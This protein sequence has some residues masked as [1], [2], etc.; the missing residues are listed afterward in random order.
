MAVQRNLRKSVPVLFQPA[1]S[2]H[3][4]LLR[5]RQHQQCC[6]RA[7]SVPAAPGGTTSPCGWM[8]PTLTLSLIYW[9]KAKHSEE[10]LGVFEFLILKIFSVFMFV[11]WMCMF[12]L[13]LVSLDIWNFE[14]IK[15]RKKS[16]A[17]VYIFTPSCTF[18]LVGHGWWW[19]LL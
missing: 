4:S 8:L 1:L 17:D 6:G 5:T 10:T 15:Q 19:V 16:I 11:E 12:C 3:S 18:Q 13:I 9:P 7:G 14:K 2:A